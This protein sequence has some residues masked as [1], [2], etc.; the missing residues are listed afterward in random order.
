MVIVIRCAVAAK[1]TASVL[2]K[3]AEIP[4]TK[5]AH[6]AEQCTKN[7]V[8]VCAVCKIVA[9]LIASLPQQTV[10]N[11]AHQTYSTPVQCR[12]RGESG[13]GQT[14]RTPSIMHHRS[15]KK[16]IC[17]RRT[18]CCVTHFKRLEPVARIPPT[19]LPHTTI[20]YLIYIDIGWRTCA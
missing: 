11:S 14:E 9:Y 19:M 4:I 17:K 1:S 2:G 13:R 12:C 7:N 18:P 10:N 6:G 16:R 5:A 15:G 20:V 8:N 3:T